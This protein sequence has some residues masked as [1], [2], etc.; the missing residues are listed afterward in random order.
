MPQNAATL[1]NLPAAAQRFV[2]SNKVHHNV[3]ASRRQ[4]VLL[5]N[6]ESLRI[7][8]PLI[9]HRTTPVLD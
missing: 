6:K 3:A 7:Q 4:S 8:H 9:V 1:P 5:L 2:G